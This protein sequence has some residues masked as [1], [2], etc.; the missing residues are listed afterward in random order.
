MVIVDT[1]TPRNTS[2]VIK[3]KRRRYEIK[4][5]GI[6]R[7]IETTQNLIID[8]KNVLKEKYIDMEKLGS[9]M[10]KCHISLRD[11]MNVSTTL[12][13]E[14]INKSLNNGAIGAKLTGT[15]M[16]GCFFALVPNN[17]TKRLV[18]VLKELPVNVYIT[19]PSEKGL[20]LR[21]K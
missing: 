20:I 17:E 21:K 13:E 12:I 8:I 7:Y 2:D 19:K 14:G 1:L 6:M 16:G 5:P 15:G 4:E 10:V 3:E 18:G 11:D 9:L